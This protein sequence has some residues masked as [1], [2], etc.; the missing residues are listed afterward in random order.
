MYSLRG[1]GHGQGHEVAAGQGE[2]EH[3]GGEGNVVAE[4]DG[5][6]G[7]RLDIAEHQQRDEHH[8]GDHQGWEQTGLLPRLQ[9]R[10]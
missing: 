8:P 6:V 9:G 7:A 4:V 2:E 1:V 5:Q 10:S 3:D